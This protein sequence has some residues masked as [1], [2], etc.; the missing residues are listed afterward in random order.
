MVPAMRSYSGAAG[1]QV[2]ELVG[3][4]DGAEVGA[5]D[6]VIATWEI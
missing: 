6:D 1:A 4:W 3:A 5:T 2:G